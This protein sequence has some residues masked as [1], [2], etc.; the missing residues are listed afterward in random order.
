MLVIGTGGLMWQ[1]FEDLIEQHPDREIYFYDDIGP[2]TTLLH[3]YKVLKS[4]NEVMD[5]FQT[6][7]DFIVAVGGVNYREELMKKFTNL[8]GSPVTLISYSTKVS[9]IK[10]I[11]ERGSLVLSNTVI[12]P[13]VRIGKGTL[14]NIQ[15]S[16]THEVQIG[17][18]CEISPGVRLL[19]K[20][21]IGNKTMIGS[22][23]VV[24]PGIRVG[25]NV[26]IGAGAVV[27]KDVRDGE[28]IMGVPG[29]PI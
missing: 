27:T 9:K 4:E 5:L 20:V 16:I 24:L 10:S 14:I 12:E 2:S 6:S 3:K 28:I 18:Y 7:T 19:G 21:V 8:G 17:E 25:S 23:A 26:K 29:K 1:M 13:F 11:I 22:G 15:C